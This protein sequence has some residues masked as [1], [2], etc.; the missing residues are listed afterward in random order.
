MF[1]P[2]EGAMSSMGR[3][4]LNVAING[5]DMN[6]WHRF[7]LRQNPFPQTGKPEYAA[8]ERKLA[9]LD[10]DPVR[11][12][13]DIRERLAGFDPGFVEGVI[14]RWQPGRR[15][16]FKIVFPGGRN[17]AEPSGELSVGDVVG[18]GEAAL[19]VGRPAGWVP[20]GG[21]LNEV[22]ADEHGTHPLPLPGHVPGSGSAP[23]PET[24]DHGE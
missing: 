17:T 15:V 10:G 7:G 14:Q 20:V 4:E 12:A 8:G 5:A 2:P 13:D 18:V 16:R 19:A 9:S 3:I 6:P 24:E 22:R 11:T 1:T 23:E 21:G